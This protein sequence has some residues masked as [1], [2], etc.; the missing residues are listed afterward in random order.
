ML[1]KNGLVIW[2]A[3]AFDDSNIRALK[4]ALVPKVYLVTDF[5]AQ[6]IRL[7]AS[8][9]QS[10]RRYFAA[11]HREVIML[12]HPMRSDCSPGSA[13][14]VQETTSSNPDSF[15]PPSHHKMDWVR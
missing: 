6:N 14:Y 10:V 11:G 15:L 2:D 4:A 3:I 1:D 13:F 9:P 12:R 8:T 5:Y 7:S